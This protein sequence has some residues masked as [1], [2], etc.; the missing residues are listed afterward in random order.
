MEVTPVDAQR[1]MVILY[2]SMILRGV[3]TTQ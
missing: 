3:G 1:L 2:S